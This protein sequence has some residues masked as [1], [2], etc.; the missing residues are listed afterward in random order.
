MSVLRF[1]SLLVLAVW[2]GGL[3]ALGIVAAPTIFAVIEAY[4]PVAG[5]VLAGEVFGAVFLRFQTVTWAAGGLL[6]A[7]LILRAVLGPRPRRFPIRL[8]IAGAMLAASLVAGLGL[9][10]RIDA[11]RRST[12]GPVAALPDS[13]ARKARFGRLH[14]WSNGLMAFVLAGGLWLTWAEMQDGH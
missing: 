5:R 7:L 6:M 8:T 13:D 3:A 2:I 10:P 9:A 1:A 4:D 14:G 11:I 12:D